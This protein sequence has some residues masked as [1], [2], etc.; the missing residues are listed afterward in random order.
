ME[1]LAGGDEKEVKGGRDVGYLNL[2]GICC[3]SSTTER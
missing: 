2:F 1:R 3:P